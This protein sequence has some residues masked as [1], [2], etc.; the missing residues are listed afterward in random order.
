M[1]ETVLKSFP[2]LQ[3]AKKRIII[4]VTALGAG[5]LILGFALW[6][7][8]HRRFILDLPLGETVK[9][10][11]NSDVV[12]DWEEEEIPVESYEVRYIMTMQKS[13]TVISISMLPEK[14]G[15]YRMT[16]KDTH[17]QFLAGDL[18]EVGR[19][20][21]AFSWE[22]GSFTGSEFILFFVL[23]FVTGVFIIM[24]TGFLKLRGPLENSNEAIFTCGVMIFSGLFLCFA[25]PYYYRHLSNQYSYPVW[26]LVLDFA[27]AGKKF[28]AASRPGLFLFSISLIVSNIA[29]LRHESPRFQNLLGILLGLILIG[30][31]AGTY[32]AS[33]FLYR[34]D[35]SYD[36][37]RV[38]TMIRNTVGLA[39]TYVECILLGTII[40]GLRAAK[41]VPVPDRDYIL[42]LGC[43]FRKDGTLTPLLKARV[44]KA[45]DFWRMQKEK[46]GKAAFIIPS[47]G[48]GRNETMPEAKAM[49][50]YIAGT[51]IPAAYV[52]PEDQSVNTFQNM[53]FS[54]D[55]ID[56]KN[57]DS[58]AAKVC[59]VTTNYHVLR[60]GIL[61]NKVKLSAEGLGAKTKWWF[62]PNAF[63]RECAAF[64]SN[65][66]MMILYLSILLAAAGITLQVTSVMY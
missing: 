62:W 26:L 1:E 49:S 30:A 56:G 23:L 41:H 19:F 22:T 38:I 64:F 37:M 2:S 8:G 13:L 34:Y 25:F 51:D 20:Q 42:I 32:A 66:N 46:T 58:S 63:V 40:C 48:Q 54:K 44:D 39:F 12:I 24:L 59:Y 16:V 29:L 31:G 15:E 21:S 33:R 4:Q 36:A 53:Q 14:A 45:L 27:Q 50:N 17:G 52:L 35:L 61:A 6:L 47:G 10:L 18:I 3:S 7:S 43:C 5:L 60:S 28:F 57:P 55:I 65:R 11:K 9:G